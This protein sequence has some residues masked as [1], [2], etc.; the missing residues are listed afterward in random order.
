MKLRFFA[1]FACLA[2]PLAAQEI[3]APLSVTSDLNGDGVPEQF[4]LRFSEDRAVWLVITDIRSFA[5]PAWSGA[6]AG[7]VPWLTRSLG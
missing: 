4:T 2:L 5:D 7:T 1:L 6:M 3:D